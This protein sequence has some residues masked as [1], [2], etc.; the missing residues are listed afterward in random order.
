VPAPGFYR[1]L[2][3]TDSAVYGGSNQGNSG[4][5]R[6]EPVPWQGQPQSLLL[7]LPPLAALVLKPSRG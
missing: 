7:T 2:L 3:N 4:G 1:E 5:A 6:A